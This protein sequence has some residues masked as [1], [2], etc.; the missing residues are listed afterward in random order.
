MQEEEQ[1]HESAPPKPLSAFVLFSQDYRRLIKDSLEKFNSEE[2]N[3]ALRKKWKEL[4]KEHKKNYQ[5][6]GRKETEKYK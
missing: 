3:R 4:P 2:I 1:K 5:E 6:L